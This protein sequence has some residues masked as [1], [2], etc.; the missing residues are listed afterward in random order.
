MDELLLIGVTPNHIS[1]ISKM[2]SDLV[3]DE[4]RE[5]TGQHFSGLLSGMMK[6]SGW[7]NS[8]KEHQQQ[9]TV[10]EMPGDPSRG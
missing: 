7:G 5:K 9:M 2:N 1:K 6:S 10:A 3:E 8:K 4:V